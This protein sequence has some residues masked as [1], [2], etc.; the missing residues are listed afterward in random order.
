MSNI[1]RHSDFASMFD[2][3]LYKYYFL[4]TTI[5]IRFNHSIESWSPRY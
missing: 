5:R 1:E 4:N 3:G 2:A